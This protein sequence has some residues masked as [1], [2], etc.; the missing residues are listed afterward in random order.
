[1]NKLKGFLALL[2]S[3]S[4]YGTFGVWVRFLE[5][6]FTGSQQI[7]V[8]NG[9]AFIFA[10]IAVKFFKENFSFKGIDKRYMA[11]YLVAFL[12]GVPAFTFGI[13]MA[14]VTTVIFGLYAG[15]LISSLIVGVMWFKE[16]VSITKM[17]AFGL[18]FLGLL[19]YV[20]PLSSDSLNLGL[21]LGLLSGLCDT[22]VNSTRKYL[23]D[24]IDRFA[25]ISLQA[26]TGSVLAIC[27]MV[28]NQ[29]F[30]ISS[31][32]AGSVISGLIYGFITV[33]VAYLMLVG[34]QSFDLNLGTIVVSSELIFASL[35]AL[36]LFGEVPKT[37]EVFGGIFIMAAIVVMN[38]NLH[39]FTKKN[40]QR[41]LAQLKTISI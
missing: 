18:V 20:Y 13:L 2:F 32:S 39:T 17:I 16:K 14:K 29:E 31:L 36:L 8:K 9:V 4:I 25:L 35:F 23:G 7:L 30:T 26:L 10:L 27:L 5:Q 15:S 6:D 21:G 22:V 33:G 24:K 19:I 38:T 12:I 41:L 40:I 1:V 34:F 28:M 11:F 37:T 3:A